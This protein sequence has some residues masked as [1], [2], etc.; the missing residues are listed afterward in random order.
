M[1]PNADLILAASFGLFMV[2]LTLT[3]IDWYW[4]KPR[5]ED[6]QRRRRFEKENTP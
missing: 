5:R 4:F 6:R 2:V 3:L 1:N